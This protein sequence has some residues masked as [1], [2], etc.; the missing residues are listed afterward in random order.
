MNQSEALGRLR[1][2]RTSFFTTRDIA[3]ALRVTPAAANMVAT[4]LATNGLLVHIARG[5]WALGQKVNP[6]ALPQYLTAPYPAYISLQTALFHH[7][8]ISQIPQVI[9]AV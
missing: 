1:K 4:R 3:A 7:G 6:L 8:M 5:R 9:Y 2:L